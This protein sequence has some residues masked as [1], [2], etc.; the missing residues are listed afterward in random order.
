MNRQ[1][2]VFA[3]P[4][5]EAAEDRESCRGEEFLCITCCH[6]HPLIHPIECLRVTDDGYVN[7]W[8][9]FVC[10]RLCCLT[11][12]SSLHFFISHDKFTKMCA[13]IWDVT[14]T[15]FSCLP[16]KKYIYSS[17]VPKYNLEVLILHLSIFK[18][19]S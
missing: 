1:R 3:H 19:F 4:Q 9:T 10:V 14:H 12:L 11:H 16:C 5:Y 17:N 18:N 8:A 13:F 15:L 7:V 6:L 2:W